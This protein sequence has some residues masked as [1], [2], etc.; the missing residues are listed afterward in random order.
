MRI[1]F[2]VSISGGLTKAIDKA[3]EL[4]CSTI[5]LFSRNPRG[6]SAQPLS[7]ETAH[8]FRIRCSE[9]DIHPVIV[10][11][12]YLPNLATPDKELWRRSLSLLI[13]ELLRVE[14]LG[15]EYLITH[16]GRVRN[17]E[18]ESA[19]QRVVDAL[20]EALS[21]VENPVVILLE[22][23]AGGRSDVG[24]TFEELRK[25][26]D[27]IDEKKRVGLCYDTAHGFQAGYA[28]RDEGE[29][30][31]LFKRIKETLGLERLKCIHLND[32]KTD[33]ASHLDRHWHIGEGRIGETG[34][35]AFLNRPEL[36]HLPI[37]METPKKDS[38]DDIRNIKTVL[39]LIGQ[40]GK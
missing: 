21:R 13:E 39:R 11:M 3:R 15:A 28:I 23:T 1:G 8:L 26:M 29:V 31:E 27:G 37:I 40:K 5:Q 2:H 12:P 17:G 16:I 9:S 7:G 30:E 20:N 25:I 19:L 4:G 35:K 32:S 33:F 24:S 10:H 22:N 6:W 34:F 36:V 38:D 18:K 14:R